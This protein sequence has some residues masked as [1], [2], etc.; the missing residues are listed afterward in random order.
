MFSLAHVAAKRILGEYLAESGSEDIKDVIEKYLT[1]SV[2]LLDKMKN[3]LDCF[4]K[5]PSEQYLKQFEAENKLHTYRLIAKCN[6][7]FSLFSG[8]A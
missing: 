3:R 4:K 6:I 5:P 2:T 8:L 7:R 1:R